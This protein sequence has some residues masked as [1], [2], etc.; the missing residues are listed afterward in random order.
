[1]PWLY[2]S[3]CVCDFSLCYSHITISESVGDQDGCL[4]Q[5]VRI[6]PY[7]C[8]CLLL[9]EQWR[10][11][12]PYTFLSE[13][14]FVSASVWDTLCKQRFTLNDCC[15]FMSKKWTLWT[16]HL[17]RRSLF[18]SYRNKLT[19]RQ[20]V[21][22]WKSLQNPF[23]L[24]RARLNQRFSNLS[25]G[26]THQTT[27]CCCSLDREQIWWTRFQLPPLCLIWQMCFN[28]EMLIEQESSIFLNM[29][30]LTPPLSQ[31]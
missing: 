3:D 28:T 24:L 1:M 30:G 15:S 25:N 27:I 14:T 5:I 16:S 8:F 19:L 21:K 12:A 26:H 7:F 23:N 22:V 17:I 2:K 10:V 18:Q 9:S 31:L 20:G 4:T 29:E 6:L 11:P 13:N